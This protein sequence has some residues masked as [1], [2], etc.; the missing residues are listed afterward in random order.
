LAIEKTR[1]LGPQLTNEAIWVV[2]MA[3]FHRC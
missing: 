1:A 2:E 3:T